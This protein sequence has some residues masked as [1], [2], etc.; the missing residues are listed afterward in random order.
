MGVSCPGGDG[1]VRPS[2]SPPGG[3]AAVSG[4]PGGQAAEQLP[5][6]AAAGLL[7][8]PPVPFGVVLV[9]DS[10]VV[11]R[12]PRELQVP[13]GPVQVVVVAR[14]V[15]WD[16]LLSPAEDRL[17]VEQG[18]PQAPAGGVTVPLRPV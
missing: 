15:G 12:E 17:G 8:G 9:G 16:V 6:G 13:A 11:V 5:L 1:G 2:P 4:A 3:T 14:V 10:E 18:D 7:L